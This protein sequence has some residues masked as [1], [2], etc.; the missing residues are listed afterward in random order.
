MLLYKMKKMQINKE[1]ENYTSTLHVL[2]SFGSFNFYAQK[3]AKKATY[4]I[5]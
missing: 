4:L 5:K 2:V 3:V 1:G